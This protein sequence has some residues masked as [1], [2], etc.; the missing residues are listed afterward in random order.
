MTR[1]AD[2]ETGQAHGL[3]SASADPLEGH[4]QV[5]LKIAATGRTPP[6]ILTKQVVE[7]ACPAKVKAQ[8]AK[9][10][11]KINPTKEILRRHVR[12][13]H[14]PL[15]VIGRAFLR[16]GEHGIG[17]G[18]LLEALLSLRSFVA[19][20]V[21]LERELTKGIFDGFLVRIPWDTQYVVVVALRGGHDH[22]L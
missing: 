17:F 16:I 5:D 22:D 1:W 6:T 14:T 18:D 13:T 2:T 3:F 7:P 20:G 12:R 15:G 19:V 9:N 21:I 10:G 8:T 11:A 4:L